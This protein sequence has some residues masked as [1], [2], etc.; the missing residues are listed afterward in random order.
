MVDQSPLSSSA[1]A[2][3]ALD[4]T[5]PVADSTAITW[6]SIGRGAVP[7]WAAREADSLTQAKRLEAFLNPFVRVAQ[8]FFQ[9]YPFAH[10]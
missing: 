4:G 7:G 2:V 10:H 8:T 9:Q 1:R 6:A 3:G 5:V